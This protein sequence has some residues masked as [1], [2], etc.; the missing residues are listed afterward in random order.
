MTNSTQLSN[1][2]AAAY[3][4]D[5]ALALFQ[6]EFPADTVGRKFDDGRVLVV[7]SRRAT[8]GTYGHPAASVTLNRGTGWLCVER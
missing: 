4:M 1:E 2:A 5:Q 3:T 7:C 6:S 8:G